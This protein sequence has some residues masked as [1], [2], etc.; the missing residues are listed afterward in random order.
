[1]A[2]GIITTGNWGKA[3]WPG[4]NKFWGQ[5][6][7]TSPSEWSKMFDVFN[8]RKQF[9]E[10]VG[11]STLGLAGVLTEGQSVSYDSDVDLVK[12][13]LLEIAAKHPAVVQD[14]EHKPSVLFN[15]LSES[16]LDFALYFTVNDP[17]KIFSGVSDINTM[18]YKEF[19]KRNIDPFSAAEH[20]I[21]DMQ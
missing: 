8:S 12:E 15:K 9:E 11:T 21:E 18:I 10:D 6:Y 5:Y 14:G 4:I 7:N 17:N 2:T 13:T 3:L 20:V 1:M 19:K 16:S